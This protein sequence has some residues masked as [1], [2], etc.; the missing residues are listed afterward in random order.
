[1][2]FRVT[3]KRV[4]EVE[5]EVEAADP[6]SVREHLADG[7][8]DLDYFHDGVVQSDIITVKSIRRAVSQKA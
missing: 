4:V 8:N 5:V 6:K 7:C 2:K 3:L 1:M